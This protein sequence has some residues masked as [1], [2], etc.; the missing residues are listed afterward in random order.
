MKYLTEE[1]FLDIKDTVNLYVS[2]SRYEAATTLLRSLISEYG[3]QSR[4]S[5]LEGMLYHRQGM[6]QQAIEKYDEVIREDEFCQE[7][8]FNKMILLSDLGNYDQ[9]RSSFLQL[10]ELIQSEN[11]MNEKLALEYIKL[12]RIYAEYNIEDKALEGFS[13]AE[14]LTRNHLLKRDIK[15]QRIDFYIKV[16]KFEKARQE[17]VAMLESYPDFVEARHKLAFVLI[18]L[19]YSDLAL[20]QWDKILQIDPKDQIALA[21]KRIFEN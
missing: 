14:L 1:R 18:L 10:D 12:S 15:I 8:Y 13:K 21:Y 11:A 20:L 9:A 16:K 6:Y 5:L 2:L 19:N 17:L 4:L 7:A 3:R